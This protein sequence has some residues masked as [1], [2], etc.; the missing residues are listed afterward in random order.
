MRTLY[1]YVCVFYLHG[2]DCNKWYW[3]SECMCDLMSAIIYSSHVM[4][5]V[6][7]TLFTKGVS[8]LS[9]THTH[10]HTHIRNELCP[11]ESLQLHEPH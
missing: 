3:T 10:P 8:S 11:V 5:V 6:I 9:Y 4:L 7:V 2:T 1:L